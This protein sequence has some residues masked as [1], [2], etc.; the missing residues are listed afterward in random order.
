MSLSPTRISALAFMDDTTLIVTS[1]EGLTSSLDIVQEFSV[2]NNTKINFEKALLICN[3]NPDDQTQPLPCP[4]TIVNIKGDFVNFNI[5][6]ITADESFRFL[7]VWFTMNL[8]KSYVKKQ[9]STEY[10]LF[11][12][13]LK[14]KNLTDKQLVYLHN[15]VLLPK[16]EYRLKGT[17]LT[18]KDCDRISAPFRSVLKHALHLTRS[19]PTNLI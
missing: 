16:V 15:A 7:G 3:R 1:K 2:F 19:F 9:C 8:N 18:R 14:N 11:C 10:R 5:T 13:T 4:P 6:P 12:N 17:I